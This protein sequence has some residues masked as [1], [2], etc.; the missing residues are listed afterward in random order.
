MRIRISGIQEILLL[1]TQKQVRFQ[2]VSMVLQYRQQMRQRYVTWVSN[3]HAE[4]DSDDDKVYIIKK[5]VISLKKNVVKLTGCSVCS[6]GYFL[7][8]ERYF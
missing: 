8:E 1:S 3:F 5:R 6:E 4:S 2:L 7:F